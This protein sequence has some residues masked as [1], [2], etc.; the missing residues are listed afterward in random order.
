MTETPSIVVQSTETPD[1]NTDLIRVFSEIGSKLH[2][3]L[4][5]SER[6]DAIFQHLQALSDSDRGLLRELLHSF[7]YRMIEL[8]ASDID[9]GGQGSKSQIWFRIFNDKRPAPE[10]GTYT[11]E[12]FGILALNVLTPRQE[13]HL[14]ANRNLDF[15]FSLE[16]KGFAERFRAC[17]YFDLDNLALN[18]RRINNF[19]WPFRDYNFHPNVIKS[20]SLEY[21]K[22]G[23]ILVTGITG[24][25]KSTTLDS[26]IDANNRS[27]NAHV[28]I[29]A[30]PVECVHKS[31]KC[32]IRHREIGKDVNSFRDGAIQ[33]LRQDPDIIMIG[34]MRD[35]ETIITAL[36]ITD[37]GHKVFSTLHTGS[38]IETIDRIVAECPVAEQERI[39]NRLA[40]VLKL[41][42]SQK[43]VPSLD[44]K[45]ILAKEILVVN[46][47]V[48]AAIKNNNTGEVYQMINESAKEG[49]F[50]MEQDL[51]RLVQARK[52]SL[53]Q[54]MNFANNK[55][56]M[57]E[58]LEYAL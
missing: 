1:Q 4:Q 8:E 51:K 22:Q 56:R 10:L 35:P 36:E 41:I 25:G 27:V 42:I 38:A 37:T 19:I 48:R 23:M 2:P 58:L 20:L 54:A 9:F 16:H 53:D 11:M 31:I 13:K 34:E 49:M 15:S 39:R 40:D 29:I 32:L 28:V 47:S 43:L 21:E 44:G 18:M 14:I 46:A 5:G 7:L 24:S 12:Q 33:A 57:Q 6:Q 45:R 26:I 3:F 30:S 50:T 55:K 17:L 52:I